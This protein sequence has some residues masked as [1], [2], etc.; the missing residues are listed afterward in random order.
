MTN[1]VTI[2]DLSDLVEPFIDEANRIL[3]QEF[4]GEAMPMLLNEIPI[5]KTVIAVGKFFN[6]AKEFHRTKM[7]ISFLNGLDNG[8][9]TMEDFNK[10]EDIDKDYLR[11]LVVSQLDM[12]SDDRQAEAIGHLFDAYLDKKVDRLMFSGVMSE[13]KNTNPL[14]YYFSVDSIVVVDNQYGGKEATGPVDLLPA[15]F[16]HNTVTG[17]G[18]W[19]STGDYKFVLTRLGLVFFKY[20]Y[21][22]MSI[23]Y[24]I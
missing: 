21:D 17:I 1:K 16:G 23:K 3:L 7:M 11:G 13:I 8:T 4:A 10:L 19:G 15:A 5:A 6:S 18:Q 2:S 12:Q 20:I 24:Q 14:L 9:K 22:P